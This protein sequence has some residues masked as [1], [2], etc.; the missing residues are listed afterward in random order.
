MQFTSLSKSIRSIGLIGMFSA[1][2]GT[3]MV[4][5]APAQAKPQT[6]STCS[7]A[8]FNNPGYMYSPVTGKQRAA[9]DKFQNDP[10]R[11]KKWTSMM[12]KIQTFSA[13]LDSPMGYVAKKVNG[14]PIKIP[15][16]IEQAIRKAVYVA[17]T[18]NNRK[19]V[20]QLNQEYGQYA[21]FGQ[22]IT[23]LLSPEQQQ[24]SDKGTYEFLAYIASVLTPQQRQ[25]Q[26]DEA[27]AAGEC[28]PG[29]LFKPTGTMTVDTGRRPDLDKRLREDKTGT[30]FFK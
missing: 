14:K 30:T 29:S 2:V 25:A 22:N 4:P 3:S 17:P 24:E 27:T 18:P 1:I 7:A 12:A 26:R 11:M 5:T 28:S 8:Y 21:T 10:D 16:K 20:A 6:G 9:V 15:P 19:R 13:P 23:L